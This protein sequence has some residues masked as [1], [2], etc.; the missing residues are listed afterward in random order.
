MPRKPLRIVT[1]AT[2]SP[3]T[4]LANA[5]RLAAQHGDELRYCHPQRAWYVWDGK[6]WK[7]DDSG[8][9]ER[10]AKETVRSIYEEAARAAVSEHRQLLASWAQQSESAPHLKAMI[11]LT[12]S[13]SGIAV[14][15]PELDSNPWLLDCLN[16]TIDLRSGQLQPHRKEEPYYQ[17]SPV[18]YDPDAVLPQ[19]TTFLQEVTGGNEELSN[20]LQQAVGYSLTAVTSEE[21]L[22]FVHGPGA[23]GKSTF[24]EATRS[25]L[26]DYARTADFEAF[27]KRQQVGG[28]RNDIACL[29]GAR[30]VISIEVD[31]GKQLA[32]GLVKMLTGGDTVTARMLYKEAIQF[33]PGFKLWLCANHAPKVRADDD[34]MWRRI[35]RIP[36]ERVIPKNQ[37]DPSLKAILKDP[38]RGGAAILAWAVKGCLEWQRAGLAVPKVVE[39]ATEKYR[40]QMDS[41]TPFLEARCIVHGNA[42]TP[43]QAMRN[44]YEEFALENL[45]GDQL[46]RTEFDRQ[47]ESRG[48]QKDRKG[49]NRDRV[50]VGVALVPVEVGTEGGQADTS[51]HRL[52]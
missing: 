28:A 42:Q 32:E 17:V 18:E 33:S 16:G 41:L 47:M 49:K 20:F 4:D 46:S 45:D 21:V 15:Q 26:G 38:A 13:E 36:F 23:T 22:F 48:F 5:R 19:W 29:A 7:Q 8:E 10:R 30:L 25:T 9:V 50:W 34:A 39:A 44:A 35:L 12:R 1:A 52:Q 6:R 40:S 24:L 37:R 51:G 3:N 27:L 14:T 43:L 11:Q 2:E 31:E